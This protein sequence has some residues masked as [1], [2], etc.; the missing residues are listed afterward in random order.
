MTIKLDATN[1]S[2]VVTCTKCPWWYGF[3]DHKAG[4]WRVGARHEERAHPEIDQ[5]RRA[6]DERNRRARHAASQRK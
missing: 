3:A 5:A 2:V 1:Y 4:G 6:L